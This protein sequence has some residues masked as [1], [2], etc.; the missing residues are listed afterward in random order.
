MPQKVMLNTPGMQILQFDRETE[1]GETVTEQVR[2]EP[3]QVR[4]LSDEEFEALQ[5]HEQFQKLAKRNQLDLN[6]PETSSGLRDV[7]EDL[8]HNSLST[9]WI[10]RFSQKAKDLDEVAQ[11]QVRTAQEALSR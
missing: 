7:R 8:L 10:R 11:D 3:G 1:E 9:K 6:P 2:L 5:E 4:E